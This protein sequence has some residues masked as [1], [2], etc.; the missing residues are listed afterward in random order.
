MRVERLY[1]YPVKGLT[2]EALEETQVNPGRAIPWDRA[3]ALAQ[4]DSLFDPAQPGWRPK[5][6]FMCLRVHAAIASLQ[7]SFDPSTGTLLIQAPDG[8]R[9][10][11]NAL[12]Q[13]GRDRIGAWLTRFLGAEAR[14]TPRFHHVEGHSFGDQKHQVVSL[15]NLASLADY[16][17]KIGARRHKRRFRPNIWFD[18]AAP[19]SELG[20]VGRELLVGTARLRVTRSITRCPATEVNPLTAER[21]ADPVAELK[22]LY[23]HTYLGVHAE[24]VEAGRIASGD[25]IEILA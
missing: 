25:A 9:L 17:A 12:E 15:I 10:I 13:E 18:G 1:R 22:R 16:E 7:S 2:A 4:G 5:T 20:W 24:V 6:E 11:E 8:S 19:M 14:G 3:F 23:G 21:D